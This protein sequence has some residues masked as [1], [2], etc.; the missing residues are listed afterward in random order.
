[1]GLRISYRENTGDEQLGKIASLRSPGRGFFVR[2]SNA[3]SACSR[4]FSHTGRAGRKSRC[5]TTAPRRAENYLLA[6]HVPLASSRRSHRRTLASLLF[7]TFWR[8]DV[9]RGLDYLR[10][11]GIQTDSRISEAIEIVI[12]R[13]PENSLA[14]ERPSSRTSIGNGNG[15]RQG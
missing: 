14:A 9:L 8:Y 10:N 1:M 12:K 7:P 3:L 11:A 13:P 15:C 4:D 6:P 5:V 2:A